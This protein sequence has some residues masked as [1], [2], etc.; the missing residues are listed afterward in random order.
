MEQLNISAQVKTESDEDP[1]W[2]CYASSVKEWDADVSGIKTEDLW[3]KSEPP[4]CAEATDECDA[5][6][7]LSVSD[8]KVPSALALNQEVDQQKDSTAVRREV[9]VKDEDPIWAYYNSITWNENRRTEISV[10]PDHLPIKQDDCESASVLPV[11]ETLT[12]VSTTK[13]LLPSKE[14]SKPGIFHRSCSTADGNKGKGA[15]KQ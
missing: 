11:N 7:S 2:A 3:I 15:I 1:I 8:Q 6:A 9:A 12:T 13:S 10:K 4:D 14:A 5:I